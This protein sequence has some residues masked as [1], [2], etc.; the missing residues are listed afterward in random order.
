MI[1]DVYTRFYSKMGVYKV[2]LFDK[3][4]KKVVPELSMM[5]PK[6]M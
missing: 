6:A 2:S 1:K 3:G 4:P 5:S